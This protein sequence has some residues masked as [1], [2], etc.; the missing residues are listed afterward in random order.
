MKL[1]VRDRIAGDKQQQTLSR[2]HYSMAS[3]GDEVP[4]LRRS[5]QH[6]HQHHVVQQTTSLRTQ[7]TA[8]S[9]LSTHHLLNALNHPSIQVKH[10]FPA[11]PPISTHISG[12]NGPIT[13]YHHY[14]SPCRPQHLPT[15]NSHT[16]LA[17]ASL[18]CCHGV[19]RSSIRR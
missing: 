2:P 19:Y 3:E 13:T 17:P 9:L 6:H 7:Q 1:L 16:H 14:P 8:F 12:P 18:L 15:K 4:E 11:P 5:K 10:A